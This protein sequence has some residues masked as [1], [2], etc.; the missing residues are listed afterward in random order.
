[1]YKGVYANIYNYWIER[2]TI[3]KNG[4]LMESYDVCIYNHFMYINSI[5]QSRAIQ[6][7]NER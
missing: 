1:M 5:M 4:T 3:K 7:I 2:Q 6:I